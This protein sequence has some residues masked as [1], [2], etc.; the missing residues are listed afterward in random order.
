MLKPAKQMMAK[1][2]SV[3]KSAHP[4]AK[5]PLLLLSVTLLTLLGLAI[6]YS[7]SFISSI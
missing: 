3:P 2:N 4:L 1:S 5:L 7:L 6:A